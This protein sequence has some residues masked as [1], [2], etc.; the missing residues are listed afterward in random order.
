V[1]AD[2]VDRCV[3]RLLADR[4][5]QGLPVHQVSD[6]AVLALVASLVERRESR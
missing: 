5:R 1:S 3:D 4:A 6:P 2:N